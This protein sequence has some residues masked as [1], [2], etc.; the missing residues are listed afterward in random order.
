MSHLPQTDLPSA[1]ELFAQR[2]LRSLRTPGSDTWALVAPETLRLSDAPPCVD[3][4]GADHADDAGPAV[5]MRAKAE[6]GADPTPERERAEERAFDPSIEDWLPPDAASDAHMRAAMARLSPTRRRVRPAVLRA[7]TAIAAL[8]EA[9]ASMFACLATPGA[10][11]AI[12]TRDPALT[13]LAA[14]I[15]THLC[16]TGALP[17]AVI[18]P[19]ILRAE[20]ALRSNSRTPRAAEDDVLCALDARLR[21][22]IEQRRAIVLVATA[23]ISIPDNRAAFRHEGDAGQCCEAEGLSQGLRGSRA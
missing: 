7:A 18:E 22:A 17:E 6:G 21:I 10:L 5:G 16:R 3:A 15:L 12:A 4:D 13:T 2:I 23:P 1:T 9:E 20:D 14:K 8:F 11:T 19:L